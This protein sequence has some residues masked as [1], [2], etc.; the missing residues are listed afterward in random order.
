MIDE[1]A[2]V[3]A[4]AESAGVR[5]Q[6]VNGVADR[7][8]PPHAVLYIRTE[9]FCGFDRFELGT[10]EPAV[11]ASAALLAGRGV[12]V[13]DGVVDVLL[14]AHGSRDVC[15]GSLGTRLAV[16]ARAD[17]AISASGVRLWQTSHTGG[18]RFAPTAISLPDG[19]LWGHLDLPLLRQIALRGEPVSALEGHLRGCSGLDSEAAQLLDER[20]FLRHGWEW[21]RWSRDDRE[22][23]GGRVAVV[24]TAA[25]G[26]SE[27]WDG[28]VSVG[29]EL[30]VPPCRS[31]LTAATKSQVELE[32]AGYR[33][34]ALN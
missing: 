20:A 11:E 29:R 5:I 1:L 12:R 8:S 18:H 14:C 22:T 25:D 26:R 33:S 21:L 30:P 19:M 23:A 24:G 2:G 13:D 16:E 32:L 27:R 9:P 15:C 17:E 10:S 34:T 4:A 31:P 7:A 3:A 28:V 6:L